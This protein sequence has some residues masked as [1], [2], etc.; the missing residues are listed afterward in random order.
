MAV[1]KS[2]L[3]MDFL[4]MSMAGILLDRGLEAHI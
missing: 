1:K 2:L 4:K 3:L